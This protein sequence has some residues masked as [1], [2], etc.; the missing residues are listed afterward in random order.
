M[1]EGKRNRKRIGHSLEELE[2][3][4]ILTL[5]DKPLI[6]GNNLNE[7][8]DVLENYEIRKDS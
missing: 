3:G 7:E 8:E 1:N 4:I 5:Q 2:D 6:S